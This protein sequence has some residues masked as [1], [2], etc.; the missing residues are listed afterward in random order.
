MAELFDKS[1]IKL[2]FN[3]AEQS[4]DQAAILQKMVA[5]DLVNLAKNDFAKARKIL[6]LGCGT[7]FVSDEIFA[8]HEI[9]NS[10]I[11]QL[12]I[13]KN[14]LIK[15][16]H[17]TH[18]I[19]ADIEALP[20]KNQ[21]F[22]LAFS[23]LS[24]QWLNDPQKAISQILKTIKD[25]GKFYFST[26]IDGTLKEL[27]QTQEECAGRASVNKFLSSDQLREI[28][29]K[30]ELTHEIKCKTITL[31]YQ[32]LYSLLKSIKSIGAT[33]SKSKNHFSKPD[34]ELMNN[35]YLKNFSSNNKVFAS[36]QIAWTAINK[37]S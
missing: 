9:S 35:F 4:Y 33:S 11:F 37:S 28:L 3:K 10:N 22:D 32:D 12:D 6:D 5:K 20:F 29:Q 2:R 30:L 13:A 7:G 25:G 15:N 8:N 26:I 1:Q 17:Q 24:F 23:S 21:I 14:L 27:K 36:W 34:F 16:P 18:K 19:N 31:E